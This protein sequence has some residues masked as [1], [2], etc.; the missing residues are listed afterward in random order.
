MLRFKKLE[1]SDIEIVRPYFDY[2][3]SMSCDVSIGGTFVCRDA[4]EAE[5]TI[6]D[7]IFLSKCVVPGD[8]PY[9]AF[10]LADNKEKIKKGLKMLE[11]YAIE[12]KFLFRFSHLTS[13]EVEILEELY[14]I[15]K[16]DMTSLEDYIYDAGSIIS[17][18][19]RKYS[20]IRNHLH[21]FIKEFPQ[22]RYE[23][24]NESNIQYVKTFLEKYI[25]H[26]HSDSISYREDIEQT[27]EVLDNYDTYKMIGGC[28]IVNDNQVVGFDIGEII[29]NVLIVHIE[30]AD[31]DYNGSFQMIIWEF[32]KHN[33]KEGM[34]VNREDAA[35]N[36]SLEIAK[37]RWFPCG[38][39]YK[40]LVNIL[41]PK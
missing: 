16:E 6:V 30:K 5:F 7:D 8:G 12:N 4:Y 33:A 27:K 13:A 38:F 29:N 37:K 3:L 34:F 15:E 24:I 32:I 20:K 35:E 28:I 17:L 11:E 31:V 23:T 21:Q 40:Y 10:P 41:G 9:F 39:V 1:L 14:N 25:N 26:P 36:E 2:T 18:S 22:Y 19:G